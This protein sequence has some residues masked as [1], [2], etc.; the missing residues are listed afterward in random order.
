MS[1]SRHLV[2]TLSVVT[3]GGGK[4]VIL[5]VVGVVGVVGVFG[6]SGFLLGGKNTHLTHSPSIYTLFLLKSYNTG[7][8]QAN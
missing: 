5:G 8:L 3:G 7:I 2:R 1:S 6:V 4:E